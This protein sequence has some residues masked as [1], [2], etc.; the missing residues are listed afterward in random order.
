MGIA[1]KGLNHIFKL[2]RRSSSSKYICPVYSKENVILSS[3]E[4][5]TCCLD[6]FGK[7]IFGDINNETLPDL[8]KHHLTD[9]HAANCLANQTGHPWPK[10]FCAECLTKG[11]ATVFGAKPTE[12]LDE[13]ARFKA[14]L[15]PLPQSLV[16]EA[17]STCNYQCI[18]CGLGQKVIN[19][20]K[21]FLDFDTFTRRVL[22]VVPE[23]YQVRL[24][25]YG[26]P[27]MH[28]QI[29]DIIA[30]LRQANP[31]L[32]IEISTNGMLMSRKISES[33]VANRVNYLTISLHGGHTQEGLMR[34]ARKGA[35]IR[36]IENNIR[37]LVECRRN[38]GSVLPRIM[39]KSLLFHWNDSDDEMQDFLRF[40]TE[41]GVD[42]A[43]WDLNR[44]DPSLSS[45]RFMLGSSAYEELNRSGHTFDH[46]Y[47]RFPPDKDETL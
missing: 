45:Q 9:F 41:L 32:V 24:Y 8:R 11:F 16:L 27:F 35:D 23:L 39:I 46:F 6:A 1:S 15:P 33:L 5:T 18:G 13:V 40:G 21:H 47:R 34:S 25:N 12:D 22:T 38:A 20:S 14:P 31:K 10:P 30:A 37:T 2:L 3:G 36:V 43:A 29:I 17:C 28:P 42:L 19:R 7:N 26:E 44:N 4:V